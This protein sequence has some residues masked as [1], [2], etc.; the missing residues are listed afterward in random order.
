CERHIN[1]G[2]SL[3]T[4]LPSSCLLPRNHPPS[5]SP[6]AQTGAKYLRE[7]LDQEHLGAG[8]MPLAGSSHGL[9]QCCAEG[10][11]KLAPLLLH[12]LPLRP[13]LLLLRAL[14]LPGL[15]HC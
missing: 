11:V 5:P 13:L 2:A 14:S 10:V 15:H 3:L 6:T 4:L 7:S 8:V 1:S 12:P 9:V